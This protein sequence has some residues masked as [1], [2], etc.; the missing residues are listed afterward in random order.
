MC[1]VILINAGLWRTDRQT[2]R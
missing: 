1:L 2:V